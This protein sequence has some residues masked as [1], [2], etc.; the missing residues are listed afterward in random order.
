MMTRLA[1]VCTNGGVLCAFW[2]LTA[3]GPA[4]PASAA[5][6]ALLPAGVRAV[7][8]L[9]KAHREA[10]PTR[11]RICINGLWRW[12]PAGEADGVPDGRWGY[13]K[14]PGC[15]PGADDYMQH[16]CQ[17]VYPHPDWKGAGLGRVSQAWYQR[18]IAVP[19]E[20]VDRR[21]TLC[22]EYLN[23]SAT[24]YV[25]GKKVGEAQFPAGKVDLTAVCQP[26]S[27][28]LL[29]LRV[30]AKPLAE[31]MLMFSDT[32]AA[33]RV[34]GKVERRG[35]CGD[36]YLA[37]VPA[38]AGSAK[39]RSIRPCAKARSRCVRRWKTCRPIDDMR[40]AR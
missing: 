36:V 23:S 1:T 35:L 37:G 3:G 7:W 32:N 28:H 5:D 2:L 40:S 10:T 4:K 9:E 21:I 27:K 16:D 18:E 39:S 30:V 13:F 31:I 34:S 14:V 8:D 6:D 15:W 11:E 29:S 12:Q 24:V 19:R 22:L 17:T 26:G 38:G 20:W 33:R 25:N